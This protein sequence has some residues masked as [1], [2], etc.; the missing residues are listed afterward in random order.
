MV[1]H[2]VW[3]IH[4]IV[5]RL[6][7]RSLPRLSLLVTRVRTGMMVTPLTS[8]FRGV[9]VVDKMAFTKRREKWRLKLRSSPQTS[10]LWFSAQTL[11]KQGVKRGCT[12]LE[13]Q[14]WGIQKQEDPEFDGQPA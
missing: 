1:L 8:L 3:M 2:C 14:H 6:H 13:S 7:L 12:R 11:L 10:F 5:A 9:S 4:M